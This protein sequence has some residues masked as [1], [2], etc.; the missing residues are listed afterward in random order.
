MCLH[1]AL[2]TSIRVNTTDNDVAKLILQLDATTGNSLFFHSA[3][4]FLYTKIARI[5][6]IDDPFNVAALKDA[7]ATTQKEVNG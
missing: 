4:R 5:W 2:Q 6:E 3:T 1:V 7:V